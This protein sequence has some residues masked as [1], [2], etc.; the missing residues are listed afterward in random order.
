MELASD[1]SNNEHTHNKS[2]DEILN[3]II[4]Q[5]TYTFDE[6]KNKLIEHNNNYVSVINE[7]INP[8]NIAHKKSVTP[9]K[10]TNQQIYYEI[11]KFLDNTLSS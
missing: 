8:N 10:S 9:N 4:R 2:I 1:L 3:I 7:Y 6:A 11:R 5:T